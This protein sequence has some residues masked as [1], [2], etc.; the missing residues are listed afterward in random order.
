MLP[1]FSFLTRVAVGEHSICSR[2]IK[3]GYGIRPYEI[4]KIYLFLRRS[5]ATALCYEIDFSAKDLEFDYKCFFVFSVILM[6]MKY[7]NIIPAVPQI[8]PKVSMATSES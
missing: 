3:G 4:V 6:I 5:Q 2:K 8:A 7:K 1:P